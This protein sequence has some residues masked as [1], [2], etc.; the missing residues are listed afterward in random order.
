MLA[1]EVHSSDWLTTQVLGSKI[2]ITDAT[3]PTRVMVATIAIE[4]FLIL[5][6]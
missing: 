2:P 5:N 4:L 6:I 3:T 1:H